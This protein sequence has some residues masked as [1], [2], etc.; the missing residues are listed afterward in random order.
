[1]T[2]FTTFFLQNIIHI[3]KKVDQFFYIII[4]RKL[5]RRVVNFYFI[6]LRKNKYFVLLILLFPTSFFALILEVTKKNLLLILTLPF[7]ILDMIWLKYGHFTRFFWKLRKMVK[8]SNFFIFYIFIV[9]YDLNYA[10]VDFH[11]KIFTDQLQF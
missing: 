10:Y 11:E 7:S 5:V 4:L 6:P 1:M 8:A 9:F 2:C 3:L